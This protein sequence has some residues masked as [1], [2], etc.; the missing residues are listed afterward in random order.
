M[1]EINNVSVIRRRIDFTLIAIEAGKARRP[2][3][4]EPSGKATIQQK[5]K[6]GREV[7]RAVV[8]QT[9]RGAPRRGASERG[10]RGAG[11]KLAFGVSHR[12]LGG[13]AAGG[14]RQGG[15]GA[16]KRGKR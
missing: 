15:G 1:V 3:K 4:L 10:S 8:A 12:G 16:K 13:S 7:E 11:G 2:P 9:E 14:K 5:K 6:V